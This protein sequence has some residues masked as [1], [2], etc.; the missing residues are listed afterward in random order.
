MDA[1]QAAQ[2][3]AQFAGDALHERRDGALEVR[4]GAL[5]E[6]L[7]VRVV[8]DGRRACE[9]IERGEHAG[10]RGAQR[11]ALAGGQ[12]ARH[13]LDE[14]PRAHHLLEPPAL[15]LD[16]LHVERLAFVVL[17]PHMR[18][19]ASPHSLREELASASPSLEHLV[20]GADRA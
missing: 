8:V 5:P 20:F 17:V 16:V 13:L 10:A 11:V 1:L 12:H 4:E 14:R 2:A 18:L 3:V 15:L 9:P 7:R 19:V 6:R